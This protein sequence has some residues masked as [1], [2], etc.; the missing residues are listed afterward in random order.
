MTTVLAYTSPALGHLFPM[1]PL[2]LELAA[3]GHDVHVRTLGSQVGLLAG[4]GLHAAPIDPAVA[5]VVH[6]DWEVVSP[7]D[8]LVHAVGVFSE[9]AR[10]DGPD[11]AAAI[12]AVRP[13][14]LI[15]DINSWGALT[16]AEASGLPWVTFSPFTPPLRAAGVPPFG[17]GLLPAKGPLGRLRDAVVRPLVLGV[18][19]KAMR[20]GINALRAE[21]GLAP[22]RTADDFFRRSDLI[23]VTTAEPF[24]YPHPDWRDDVLMIGACAWEPPADPPAWLAEVERPIVLVTT[25]SEFQDDAV[26]VR[27]AFAAL[28]D[29]DVEVVATMP[30][31]VAADIEVPANGRLEPFVPHGPL[32]DRAALAITHGG[33]GATQKALAR[34][35]PVVVVPFG[36]DQLE[37]AARV[38]ASGAGLRVPARRLS[39]ER[40]RTAALAALQ[41][42]GEA[43]A[44]ADGYAAAG[45]AVAGADAVEAVGRRPRAG[46]EAT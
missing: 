17:P 4:L 26:L 11:L 27:T 39:P 23:L 14:V 46:A 8:A 25:S 19:E 21:H 13:D 38:Q 43:R 20:P 3:R 45:G 28:A 7:K 1:T 6:D 24:E 12:E 40:L 10:I 15:V 34:G 36:R 9:R 5:D 29:H 42:T 22:V 18:A 2:L 35:V 37:V 16:V 30:A 41:R 32:L 33:M 31:G 44:V